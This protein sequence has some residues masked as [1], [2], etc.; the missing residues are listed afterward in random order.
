MDF[1][2]QSSHW[3]FVSSVVVKF[4]NI[5]TVVRRKKEKKGPTVVT[6]R[7]IGNL[8]FVVADISKSC[9]VLDHR[10]WW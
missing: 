6:T 10:L 4:K 3:P 9:R 8:G 7:K 1:A 5:G 2:E